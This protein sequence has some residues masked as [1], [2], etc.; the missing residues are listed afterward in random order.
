MFCK[1]NI[2]AIFPL[3]VGTTSA[4]N[5][6]IGCF[7]SGECANS[8]V[9]GVSVVDSINECV[10]FCGSVEACRFYTYD[11]VDRICLAL[12]ECSLLTEETCANCVSGDSSCPNEICNFEGII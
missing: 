7:V 5:F 12:E 10:D 3:I 11:A 1:R 6:T 9:A 4:Q 8:L 2:L